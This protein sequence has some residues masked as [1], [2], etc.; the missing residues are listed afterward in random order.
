MARLHDLARVHAADDATAIAILDA[1]P[2]FGRWSAEV[3]LLLAA[4]RADLFPAADLALQAGLMRLRGLAARPDERRLRAAVAGWA[5]WR[6]AGAL[7]LWHLY[8]A[9][10]L[11]PVGVGR[12]PG[13]SADVPIVG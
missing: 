6:G 9:A 13:N 7:F 1:L 11:D 5:P 3:Y 12:D 8:G 2:G 10:T 4:G